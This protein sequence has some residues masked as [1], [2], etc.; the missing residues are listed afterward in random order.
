VASR[1]PTPELSPAVTA[2]LFPPAALYAAP[3]VP[4]FTQALLPGHWALHGATYVWVPPDTKLR[5]VQP[6][7]PVPGNYVW[8]DGA[9]VWVPRHN[10]Y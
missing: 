4:V 8:Q 9:Y 3:E 2:P 7:T 1:T 6:I 10:E 5:P